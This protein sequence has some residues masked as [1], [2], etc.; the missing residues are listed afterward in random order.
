MILFAKFGCMWS[1]YKIDYISY[2]LIIVPYVCK[3]WN[4]HIGVALLIK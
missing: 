4:I 3:G 2:T 1:R